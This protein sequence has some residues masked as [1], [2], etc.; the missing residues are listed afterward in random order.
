MV[1]LTVILK[2]EDCGVILPL[3]YICPMCRWEPYFTADG[4]DVMEACIPCL[5]HGG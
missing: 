4:E 5:L 3:N 1:G 2:C